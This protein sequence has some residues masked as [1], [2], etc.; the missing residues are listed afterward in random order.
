MGMGEMVLKINETH[1]WGSL[2]FRL[3]HATEGRSPS[4]RSTRQS[5]GEW[6]G[7]WNM[8]GS[9]AG[10]RRSGG[11]GWKQTRKVSRLSLSQIRSNITSQYI[12]VNKQWICGVEGWAG[13]GA[14][15]DPEGGSRSLTLAPQNGFAGRGFAGRRGLLAA[16]G[17]RQALLGGRGCL[18]GGWKGLSPRSASASRTER[19]KED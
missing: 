1:G 6:R 15:A 11:F 18:A 3:A 5:A 19:E 17:T 9:G 8:E 7:R 12:C 4:A 2:G 10:G 13:L 16:R 14:S